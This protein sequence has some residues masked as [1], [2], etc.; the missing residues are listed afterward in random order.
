MMDCQWMTFYD[1]YVGWYGMGWGWLVGV[2]CFL[3]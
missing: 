3:R 2:G 1:G